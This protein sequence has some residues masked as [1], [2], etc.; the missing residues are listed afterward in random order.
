MLKS[1]YSFKENESL[2]NFR[3]CGRLLCKSSIQ[4][5]FAITI[6]LDDLHVSRPPLFDKKNS[7]RLRCKSSREKGLI[8]H[9]TKMCQ[10]FDFSWT[11]YTKVIQQKIKKKIFYFSK[12]LTW[13]SSQVSFAIE[14][15]NKKQISR[16]LT[17]KS[18]VRRLTSSS[19]QDKQ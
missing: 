11:T 5:I 16:R 1:L 4:V 15:L 18:S 6:S 17:H 2:L 8:L 3:F 19:V 13:K 7:G 9:L 10:K 12:R 14:I